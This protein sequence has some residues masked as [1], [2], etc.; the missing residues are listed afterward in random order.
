MV[1]WNDRKKLLCWKYDNAIEVE[2]VTGLDEIQTI[3]YCDWNV[4]GV[5][6]LQVMNDD[7]RSKSMICI[8]LILYAKS[9]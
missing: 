9:V 4:K 8:G 2:A 3:T 1:Y 7:I 5:E 6:R